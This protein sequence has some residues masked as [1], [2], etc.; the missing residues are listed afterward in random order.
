MTLPRS[1]PVLLVGLCFCAASR[2]EAWADAYA[3]LPVLAATGSADTSVSDAE[4]AATTAPPWNPSAPVGASEPWEKV[5]RFPL[6]VATFPLR[7]LGDGLEGTLRY[8]EESSLVP[9][10]QILVA[11]LPGSASS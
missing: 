4:L 5:V 3:A 7:L 9:R 1:I 10:V 8:V 2:G 11:T 6:R